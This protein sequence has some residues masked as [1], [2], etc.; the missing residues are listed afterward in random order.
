MIY[1]KRTIEEDLMRQTPPKAV[2]IYGAR[3]TGK[4]TV[5]RELLKNE[6][7]VWYSGDEPDDREMLRLNSASDVK[8]LLT[9]TRFLVIDEAQ[10]IPDIG[11]TL[12]RLV[13]MNETLKEPTAIFVTGSSALTLAAG[14][15]ESAMG[16]LV[17]RQLWPLSLRELA[18]SRG[19]GKTI[20]NLGWHM[21]YGLFPEVC[22][23]PEEAADTLTDYVDSLLLKIFCFGGGKNG[24]CLLKT[25]SSTLH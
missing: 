23:K 15:K 24:R 14:V 7:V 1:I 25:S 18:Q 2:V 8:A 10:R 21:V 13:D 9:R 6:D 11:L 4:T 5:L 16:R 22:N 17:N 12:K 3:R 19:K 20:Q